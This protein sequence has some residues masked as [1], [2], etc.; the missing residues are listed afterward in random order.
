MHELRDRT[1]IGMFEPQEIALLRGVL[2]RLRAAGHVAP[3]DEKAQ[4]LARSAI[5]LYRHGVCDPQQIFETLQPAARLSL[6]AHKP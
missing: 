2:S 3:D 4:A 5:K 1:H 6:T